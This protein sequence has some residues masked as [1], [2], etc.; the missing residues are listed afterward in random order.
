MKICGSIPSM[1][2]SVMA[3]TFG[4]SGLASADSAALVNALKRIDRSLCHSLKETCKVKPKARAKSQKGKIPAKTEPVSPASPAKAETQ[5]ALPQSVPPLPREKPLVESR[6]SA[7]VPVPRLKP[8]ESATIIFDK[9][10]V[11][12]LD[13]PHRKSLVFD[14]DKDCLQK[15]GAEGANFTI[16]AGVADMVVADA[17][18][19]ELCHVQ[20]PVR[21]HAVKANSDI[22]K[23]PESPLLNCRQALQFSRWLRESAA[24]I[25]ITHFA[26]PLQKISTGPGYECRG[27]NGDAT[28]K[29]SE[30]GRGNAVDITTFTMQNGKILNVADAQSPGA[31]THTVLRGL[32]ASACGYFTTVL[33]PG[34]NAAHASHFHF[35]IG[36]HGKSG[37]YRIC[38]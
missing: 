5:P 22:I 26:A 18:R 30:H 20:N 11:A 7:P 4:M 17:P 10:S 21:V 9:P 23:L 19:N 8:Q 33:G 16:V 38:E 1:L 12:P 2:L 32:R 6:A 34:S 28:A 37:N 27:R 3:L 13:I 29:I 24:P 35:D 14:E 36:I 25:L 31:S 15:L